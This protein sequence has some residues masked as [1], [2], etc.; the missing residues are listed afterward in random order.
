MSGVIA[1]EAAAKGTTPEAIAAGYAAGV[2]MKTFVTAQDVAA[3]AVF[4]A[5][6]GAARIS[7]QIIAVDGHT[8][9][10]DP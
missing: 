4:L 1:R 2:S 10:P 7:G 3:M 5:S 9:N 6:P 8:V